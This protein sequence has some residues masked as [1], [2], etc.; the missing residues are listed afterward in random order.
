MAIIVSPYAH[1][2]RP[3][4]AIAWVLNSSQPSTQ[5]TTNPETANLGH[6]VKCFVKR[7]EK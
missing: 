3:R 5:K 6:H 4:Q 1:S 7:S 2:F